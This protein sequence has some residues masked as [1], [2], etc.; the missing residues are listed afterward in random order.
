[1]RLLT[2]LPTLS[3]ALTTS[4]TS[5]GS[6]LYFR[7]GLLSNSELASF[8]TNF[9]D[10]PP[11]TPYPT[12]STGITISFWFKPKIPTTVST[13][14]VLFGDASSYT[15][16]I[17]INPSSKH[18]VAVTGMLGMK[19]ELVEL[20]GDF[21]GWIDRWQHYTLTSDNLAAFSSPESP[22]TSNVT[23]YL[24]GLPILANPLSDAVSDFA[25]SVGTSLGTYIDMSGHYANFNGD[26]YHG[27]FDELCIY[28]RALSSHEV[29]TGH[30]LPGDVSDSTLAMYY[31]FDD[32]H[33]SDYIPNLGSAGSH[34]DLLLGS[35]HLGSYQLGPLLGTADPLVGDDV[36]RKSAGSPVIYCSEVGRPVLVSSGV[37]LLS[38]T[39][40]K[41]DVIY[42]VVGGR[43]VP[44]QLHGYSD[45]EF[46]S[47]QYTLLAEP[48]HGGVTLVDGNTAVYTPP[49][50]IPEGVSSV[51]FS[52]TYTTT[53]SEVST[54]SAASLI[55]VIFASL[56]SAKDVTISF[57]EDTNVTVVLDAY[58]GSGIDLY[59]TVTVLPE[60]G[61][62]YEMDSSDNIVQEIRSVPFRTHCIRLMYE[63]QT[64]VEFT[65]IFSFTATNLNNLTSSVATVTLV[66]YNT[67][68]LPNP[69][70][71]LSS[72]LN[73]NNDD[74][75]FTIR[76]NDPDTAYTSVLIN[77]IPALGTL[78]ST[79]DGVTSQ[80]D[81]FTNILPPPLTQYGAKILETS[82]YWPDAQKSWHPDQALGERDAAFVYGD[83]IHGLAFYCRDGCDDVC[84]YSITTGGFTE[85][86]GF[87]NFDLSD[88][89]TRLLDPNDCWNA[90][91]HFDEE[92]YTEFFTMQFEEHVY[93][94]NVEIGENRGGGSI[95]SIEAYNYAMKQFVVIWS[96]KPD[97]EG[98]LFHKLTNQYS[99]F[100]PYPLCQP[101]FKTDIIKIK[102]DTKTINDW[103][104]IDYV[105]LVGSTSPTPGILG[106]NELT[107]VP[108]PNMNC[109]STF[110]FSLSDCGGHA[111]HRTPPFTYTILPHGARGEETGCMKRATDELNIGILAPVFP[112]AVY[113]A[114][115]YSA[116]MGAVMAIE[117]I[118]N[119]RDH[120]YD[121][122]LPKTV[123][124]F[125]I[126]DSKRSPG[127][128]LLS[129]FQFATESFKSKGAD[130]VIGPSSST[131][132]ASAQI[133]LSTFG[134]PQLS[135]GA[136]GE[137]IAESG[138]ESTFFRNVPSDGLQAK[139][140]V[141]FLASTLSYPG[142]CILQ[143]SYSLSFSAA[144]LSLAAEESVEIYASIITPDAPSPEEAERAIAKL[145]KRRCRVVV[146]LSQTTAAGPILRSAANRGIL[147]ATSSWVWYFPEAISS[148]I[149]KVQ[150]L[151]EQDGE[152]KDGTVIPGIPVLHQSIKGCFGS[153]PLITRSSS[154]DAF[155]DRYKS[156]GERLGPCGIDSEV[157]R[158]CSCYKGVDDGGASLY[159]FD[160][161]SDVDTPDRCVGINHTKSN[162]SPAV[163]FAYDGIYAIAH[164]ADDIL[165]QGGETFDGAAIIQ[166]LQRIEFDGISGRIGFDSDGERRIGAGYTIVNFV[167]GLESNTVALCSWTAENNGFAVCDKEVGITW[168][169]LSNTKPAGV[170][171]PPS[172]I[173]AENMQVIVMLAAVAGVYAVTRL[174]RRR[175]KRSIKVSS[176]VDVAVDKKLR[177]I[178]NFK[179]RQQNAFIALEVG[180]VISDVISA[181]FRIAEGSA[182]IPAVVFWGVIVLG[183]YSLPLGIYQTT[184]RTRVKTSLNNI[185]DG[186]DPEVAKALDEADGVLT[187]KSLRIRHSL[188]SL[189]I[190]VVRL[191]IQGFFVEDLPSL[192]LNTYILLSGF[193]QETLAT[194]STYASFVALMFSC[195]M[196][197]RKSGLRHSLRE[198]KT[199][200]SDLE[201]LEKFSNESS[202]KENLINDLNNNIISLQVSLQ[203][204]KH[205]E[206]ELEVMRNAMES[207]GQKKSN[208]L[209]EVLIPSKDVE[210]LEVLGK[211]GFGIVSL[212]LIRGQFV[213]VKQL[214]SINGDSARRFRFEC[215][216][217]KGL[218]HPNIV[219]LIGVVW[220][221]TM[222]ACCLE[223]VDNNTLEHWLRKTAGGNSYESDIKGEQRYELF[224]VTALGFDHSTEF[225]PKEITKEDE[226]KLKVAMALFEQ[227][228][229]DA[230]N[231]ADDWAEVN[232]SADEPFDLDVKAY[233]RYDS[234]T[235]SANAI[236]CAVV[237]AKPTQVFAYIADS[238]TS[239]DFSEQIQQ[240][241]R[242]YTSGIYLSRYGANSFGMLGVS[243]R[244][245]LARSVNKPLSS[246]EFVRLSY[247]FEDPIYPVKDC[248]RCKN[249]YLLYVRP[250]PGSNGAKSEVWRMNEMNPMFSIALLGANE[251][252]ARR[253]LTANAYPLVLV[254]RRVEKILREYARKNAKNEGG[255]DETLPLPLV[256]MRGYDPDKKYD[257]ALLTDKD[258]SKSES[259]A[260]KMDVFEGQCLDKKCAANW[261]EVLLPGDAPL[262]VSARCWGRYNEGAKCGEA[263]A[264]VNIRA[265][266][267]QIMALYCD[268]RY[269][270]GAAFSDV[271]VLEK[272]LMSRL[273]YMKMPKS[274]IPGVSD[275]DSLTRGVVIKL[276]RGGLFFCAYQILD[277]RRPEE[278]GCVRLFT[279][280]G[281]RL[282]SVEGSYGAITLAEC[283]IRVDIKL[284]G[285][286]SILSAHVI[287][288]S[289]STTADPLVQL[290]RDAERY[291]DLYEPSL[292]TSVTGKQALTWKA[293]LFKIS[294]HA[295]LGMQYLHMQRYWS[296]GD[297]DG[298][299]ES[300]KA[301]PGYRS[302]IVH[303]DL[304]PENMLLTK[305][306]NM[307]LTDF[308]EARASD[309]GNQMTQVGTPIYIAPEVMKGDKYDS[310]ADCYSMGICLVAMIRGENSIMEYYLQSL[311]KFL[312][313]KDKRGVGMAILNNRIYNEGWRPLLPMEFVKTYPSLCGL[314]YKLWSQDPEERPNFDEIVTA[315]NGKI[316]DEISSG[317]EP[318]LT[319]LS[320]EDDSIYAERM[321]NN[322]DAAD[323]EI[324]NAETGRK[325]K[326]EEDV[327][328][329]Q[330]EMVNELKFKLSVMKKEKEAADGEVVKLKNEN[331]KML[332]KLDEEEKKRQQAA[333]NSSSGGKA[334]ASR[335]ASREGVGVVNNN[336]S[337]KGFGAFA[338]RAVENSDVEDELAS[339]LG[340]LSMKR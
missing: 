9:K 262:P 325:E 255:V 214:I 38:S 61:K 271:E 107:Y 210:I 300:T 209:K 99:T 274:G 76:V 207:V 81:T 313:K 205:S 164:A 46:D 302:C 316:H 74:V 175:G 337:N 13:Y 225:N 156:R 246:E 323:V 64:N 52:Y 191:G 305:D 26:N 187:N 170:Y 281:L 50:S 57:V 324:D 192:L 221:E 167:D 253:S 87:D 219:G 277:D 161:D 267:G 290:K 332:C 110:T 120:V 119:K 89:V 128:A 198:L 79:V 55:H 333:R 96:G 252:A 123:V 278:K 7:G 136:T 8:R 250:Q 23:L 49:E 45:S 282:R 14:M 130:V 251:M 16:Q 211:G 132:A 59:T 105:K 276:E 166:A 259:L 148:D 159:M 68:D 321:V 308:G 116:M 80:V 155:A 190:V 19:E 317:Q 258:K 268:E 220:D 311:R 163:Y 127:T 115:G 273:D 319:L 91:D 272:D 193:Q 24:N 270:G 261:K 22:T 160:H 149:P 135:Y 168:P 151:A 146:L 334:S 297:V 32:S 152:L 335:D 67:N 86:N 285:L 145:E 299:G 174:I 153:T 185:I 98:Y 236:A 124:K 339:M 37:D 31:T 327:R 48:A 257:A 112:G 108:P 72:I 189:E 125:E 100:V 65:N 141:A 33:D 92:G 28:T 126:I 41:E 85:A 109:V 3:N 286:A 188:L 133:V 234:N 134:I 264:R 215:F 102:M 202:V 269:S 336:S 140:I 296:D 15:S 340:S 322:H 58:D 10:A 71:P 266:P 287:K 206:E 213:A 254:K 30:K 292:E 247:T 232:D 199:K 21:D 328:R 34:F 83:S 312:K 40:G 203:K 90:N 75:D 309:Q 78:Y 244:E 82:T 94:S 289:I 226:E 70:L 280:Y 241:K 330:M 179:I 217:M 200:K 88:N 73:E 275:R 245:I 301:L 18:S 291:L 129:A 47:D 66:V 326:I 306:W 111:S 314:I 4:G 212:G 43:D 35:S 186:T 162:I 2:V 235:R 101:S 118:N 196:V 184:Q 293:Q 180:D 27:E 256:I 62:L 139:A 183:A 201:M 288:N 171:T 298:G 150:K 239:T 54:T 6:S 204:S 194:L 195:I 154:Y 238:R 233:G 231:L 227:W 144:V 197:G 295:A 165:S 60:Y 53:S 93:I 329:F 304:K 51:S 122:L 113:D 249:L 279:E 11:G 169:T 158:E 157:S 29:F 17:K 25:T 260:A 263:Y 315:L 5:S 147:G 137:V 284:S 320:V 331:A 63:P 181:V 69:D 229:V 303:R 307:K 237:D 121:T 230:I 265:T 114:G 84:G 104:E 218:R 318:I 77:T 56:P 20:D 243:D 224:E 177:N 106:S 294:L 36:C 178:L 142:F 103:N 182:S 242:S 95:V 248:V 240:Y 143:D 138:S 216:L 223:Y 173:L 176:E 131:A 283:C 1:V 44:V 208:E 42:A 39:N 228:S 97:V 338:G 310:K 117:E 12:N 222:L 172:D